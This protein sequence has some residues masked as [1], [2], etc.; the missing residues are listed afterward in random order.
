[1]K[2]SSRLILEMAIFSL[3][4]FAL[5]TIIIITAKSDPYL[6]AKIEKEKSLK[7]ITFKYLNERKII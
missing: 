3:I 5:L 6:T 7:T 1:M 2:E 4:L